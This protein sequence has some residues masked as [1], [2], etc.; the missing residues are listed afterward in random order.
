MEV[1]RAAMGLPPT[2]YRLDGRLKE[3]AFGEWEGFT[4]GELKGIDRAAVRRRRD[5]KWHFVPPGGE[6]Y[7]QLGQRLTP[8]I[9]TLRP[10]VVVVAHG[11]VARVLMVLLTGVAPAAAPDIDIWQ[12]R[13]LTF[14]NGI[15]RWD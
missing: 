9:E 13:V 1:A 15:C 5:A 6:S 11:G 3:L 7:E 4:W 10:D 12:G 8:W 14:E 2:G